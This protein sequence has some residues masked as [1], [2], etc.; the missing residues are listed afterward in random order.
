[1]LWYMHTYAHQYSECTV[2]MY[3]M[4][5]LSSN[6]EMQF[7]WNTYLT[8]TLHT[9]ISNNEGESIFYTLL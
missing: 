3:V 9:F 8:D 6:T 4:I 5:R 7:V 1:M 2:H